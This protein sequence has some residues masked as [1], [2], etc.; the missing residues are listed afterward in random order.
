MDQLQDVD[1]LRMLVADPPSVESNRVEAE[2]PS[3]IRGRE[4]AGER[5]R[6][7]GHGRELLGGSGGLDLVAGAAGSTSRRW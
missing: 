2:K 1:G 6:E 3:P 4:G 7:G 5:A